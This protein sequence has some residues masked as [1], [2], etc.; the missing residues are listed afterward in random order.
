[1]GLLQNG[2]MA[3]ISFF[4]T[5]NEANMRRLQKL[6]YFAILQQ[7]LYLNFGFC[8][9]KFA[10]KWRVRNNCP[11]GALFLIFALL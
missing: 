10:L 1:M 5:A 6:K 9:L 3:K 7:F 2:E 11:T 4:S 8:H